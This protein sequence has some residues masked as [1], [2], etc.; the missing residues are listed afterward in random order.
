MMPSLKGCLVLPG[1]TFLPNLK[2]PTVGLLFQLGIAAEMQCE[3]H[4]A[5]TQGQSCPPQS[6]KIA[7]AEG[8]WKQ[9]SSS[10]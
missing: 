7:G 3:A 9:A 6:F 4:G 10:V 5:C 2:V 8:L 1:V